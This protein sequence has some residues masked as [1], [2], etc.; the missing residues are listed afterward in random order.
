MAAV[1]ERHD[2][3]LV[4]TERLAP[5]QELISLSGCSPGR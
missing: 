2:S 4:P 1:S 5:Y 3:E